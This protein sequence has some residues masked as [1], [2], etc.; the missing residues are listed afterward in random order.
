MTHSEF[1]KAARLGKIDIINLRKNVP[2]V[3]IYKNRHL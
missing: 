1:I 2:V 3:G